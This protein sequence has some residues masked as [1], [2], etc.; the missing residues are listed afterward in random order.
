MKSNKS[1]GLLIIFL[2]ITVA[3]SMGFFPSVNEGVETGMAGLV[4]M[5]NLDGT[6]QTI[7][8]AVNYTRSIHI[9]AMLLV[10]FGF[11]MVFLRGHEFSSLTATFLA[12][13]IAIPVYMAAK[14]FLP[15]EYQVMNISG[16]L[17]A[18]FAAASLL[19][20]MGAVLG[21]L[22]MDQYFILA[23]LFTVGYIFNEWLLLESGVFRGF[24][25]TGGSVAIHAFGAY[26]GLGVVATTDRK[27]KNKPAPKTNKVSN[28]FCLLGSMVLWLFWPSFTSSVASPERTYLTAL[29]TVLALCG[30]TLATYIFTKLI[31]GKI[32]V[33]DIANAALAGGVWDARFLVPAPAQ[34]P[35]PQTPMTLEANNGVLS[36]TLQNRS[37][38]TLSHGNG[39][40]A[41][42]DILL[43]QTWYVLPFLSGSHYA[44]TMEAYTLPP[45]GD[46]A[47]VLWQ[48]PYGVL[49]SGTYR[50]RFSWTGDPVSGMAAAPV[51]LQGGVF[52]PL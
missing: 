10:G 43:G 18:E 45:G 5:E 17:F 8:D 26:F 30:S 16:F 12:V 35:S 23:I 38:Q 47:G 52:L 11:L 37:G 51:R 14:S 1:V 19:I 34:E 27:F 48:E 7:F 49:P 39:D 28:E 42:L 25:D 31:R 2:L 3:L 46:Y 41:Q 40:A 9:L 6:T 24:L 21:R 33:E 44:Y 13:S 4:P 36:W 50:V 20:C 32:E 22:K 29:N 15:G